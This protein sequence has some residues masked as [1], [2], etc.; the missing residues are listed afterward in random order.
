MYEKL[1]ALL[2]LKPVDPLA[3]YYD[4]TQPPGPFDGLS[5]NPLQKTK[6]LPDGNNPVKHN[7]AH[8]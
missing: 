7:A 8:N 5:A 3:H 6:R 1:R 4:E 2:G